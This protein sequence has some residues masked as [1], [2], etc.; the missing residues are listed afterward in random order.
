MKKLILDDI[1]AFTFLIE[2]DACFAFSELNN[3]G[4][5]LLF[6]VSKLS[7]VSGYE[8][9]DYIEKGL[10]VQSFQRNIHFD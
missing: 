2:S 8:F 6:Y 7:A 3:N 4:V 9:F 1:A 10:F 5:D